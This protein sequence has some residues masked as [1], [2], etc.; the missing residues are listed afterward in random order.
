MNL[1]KFTVKSREALE[2]ARGLAEDMHHQELDVPHLMHALCN[3]KE[4]IVCP[5]LNKIG[6]DPV[7]LADKVKNILDRTPATST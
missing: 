4:G 3:Q 6:A 5:V 2:S 7:S 1:E